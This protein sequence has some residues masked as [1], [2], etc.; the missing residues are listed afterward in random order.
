MSDHCKG[1]KS[2]LVTLGATR[3]APEHWKSPEDLHHPAKPRGEFPGGLPVAGHDDDGDGST[4]RDFLTLMGFG[5]AAASVAACR[6]PEQKAIPLPVASDQ[7]I[8]GVPN[9]YATTCGGCASACSLLVK[10][11][12][13]R[14]IKIEGNDL[15]TLFGGATCATGQ[16]TV[17]SLYDQERLHG[18]LWNGMSKEWHDIDAEIAGKLDEAR[19][20]NGKVVLL[21]STITSPTTLAVIERWRKAVPSFRHVT[22]DAVSASGLRTACSQAFGRPL[23]PHYLFDRARVIVGIDADF[24]GTWLSPVEF[25]RQYRRGRSPE[26]PPGLHVQFEPGLSVTGSNADQRVPVAPSQLGAVAASLLVR[27]A[28]R[29]GQTGMPSPVDPVDAAVLD[30]VADELWKQ[31]GTSLVVTGAN[32]TATQLTVLTINRLLGNIGKTL[33]VDRPSRQRQGDD[34][35]MA[36]LVAEMQRGGIHTLILHGVNPAYDYI[37]SPGFVAGLSKVAL[38][39]TTADRRDETSAAALAFAA[40]DPHDKTPKP[41]HAA[42]PDHHFLESWGD[43]EPVAGYLSLT[44]PTIAPL[45]DTR[46][47]VES[48][49]HWIGQPTTHYALLRDHW[50]TEIMPRQKETAFDAFWDTT[51]ERGVLE[52]ADVGKV[53]ASDASGGDWAAALAAIKT[54]APPASDHYELALTESV[55]MRDGKNANNPWLLELPD[56]ITGV[57]WDNVCAI[58][59]ATAGKLGVRTGDIVALTTKAGTV[60]LPA[61]IQPGQHPRTLSVA[62]GWGHSTIGKAGNGTGVN[63]FAHTQLVRGARRMWNDATITSTGRRAKLAETQRHFSMEG[64]PIVLETTRAELG[65]PGDAEQLPNLWNERPQGER[66]WGMSIDLDA[67]TGCSACVVAC[68]AENNVPVIGKDQ[69]ERQRIM[70]WIRIDRYYSGSEDNPSVVHQPMMCQH[71]GHA[72]CETVCP[73]LATTTSAEGLN[74]QVYNRCIGTRYCANNCPYKVRR[75]NWYNYTENSRFDY[76]MANPVGRLVLNPDVTVRSRG[77]MEKCSLCVQRIAAAKNAS[78]KTG[79]PIKDGQIKTACQQVCPT[80]AIVFGDLNDPHSKVAQQV[81]GERAYRVLEDLGTRPNVAYLK[82]VRHEAT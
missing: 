20:T 46:S 4:R 79:E 41:F 67:C 48:L 36:D 40:T 5:A 64:R 12:D 44:Q 6:A 39:I 3:R 2:D 72:P 27:I 24:L 49:L 76:N 7:L 32:D 52:L 77:V 61:L 80:D 65:R 51:L 37:D 33:D 25:A 11:R 26:Q 22:Y 47:V 30:K 66:S 28:R 62:V 58:A 68:Q 42:C 16:A 1:A 14:P 82:K 35:A 13:G 71:C 55:A 34:A 54:D 45:Y 75:F 69:V 63:V 78:V 70:H 57:T 8:A 19:A 10:Q 38:S 29:A 23:V 74:Q 81:R 43:A 73:V 18:P 50:R 56:P 9:F 21:S 59:P 17:L 60:E 15:S 53:A 31:R